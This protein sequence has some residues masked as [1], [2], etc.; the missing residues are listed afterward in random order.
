VS[1]QSGVARGYFPVSALQ[2]VDR[3]LRRMLAEDGV[4]LDAFYWCPHYPGGRVEPFAV[5]CD[6]RKPGPGLI[7]RA[8]RD[9]HLDLRR[10]WMAGDILDDVEAGRRAGCRAALVDAG[11]ETEWRFSPCR[12]PDVVV[13]SL[14]Q[15]ARYILDRSAGPGRQADGVA[16]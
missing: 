13:S 2:C 6:C 16:E 9:H 7:T 1:N 5:A 14:D 4:S 15:L 3:A 8:A 10:C 12:V 11:H